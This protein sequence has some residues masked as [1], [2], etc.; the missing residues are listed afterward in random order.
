MGRNGEAPGP[1]A[2]PPCSAPAQRLP[3][4]AFPSH[5]IPAGGSLSGSHCPLPQSCGLFRDS[6]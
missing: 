2:T 5:V 1:R 4:S 6:G 3:S